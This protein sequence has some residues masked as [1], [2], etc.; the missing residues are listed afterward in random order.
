MKLKDHK[1]SDG[2][3]TFPT[4]LIALATNFASAFQKIGYI[5][6]KEIFKSEKITDVNKTII[7]ASDLKEEIENL[8]LKKE[9]TTI[10]LLDIV[11]MYSSVSFRMVEKAVKRYA[12]NQT[13]SRR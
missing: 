3:G 1:K 9:N 11:S 5:G 7:Q 13:A 6:I 4:R 12:K 2:N 10:I 8:N